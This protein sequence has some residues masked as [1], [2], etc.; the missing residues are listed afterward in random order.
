MPLGSSAGVG[1]GIDL[2][3]AED[4]KEY[5]ENLGIEYRFG[6]YHEKDPKACHLLGDYWEGIKKNFDK[7][8]KTYEL[9]CDD[10]KHGKS[11]HKVAGYRYY[12][13]GCQADADLSFDYFVKGCELGYHSSCLSAGILEMANPDV[14]SYKRTKKPD[15]GHGLEMYKKACDEGDSAE[16]CHRYASAFIKGMKDVC[17]KNMEEAFKYSLKACELGNLGGCTNLTIMYRK[18]D[19]VEKNEKAADMY[20]GI[21]TEM[22]AQLE[23]ERRQIEFQQGA[24]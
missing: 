17:S 20:A 19:G 15:P 21:V 8:Y 24:D 9:N 18:G 4:V 7:A 14:E 13:K 1:S 6:C 11:C 22:R 5:V 10:H 16:S 3:D 12:G 23:E 2:K